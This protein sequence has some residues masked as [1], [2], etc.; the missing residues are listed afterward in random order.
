[1]RIS[2]A[3]GLVGVPAHVLRHWEDENVL[4][5]DRAPGNQRDYTAQHVDEARII[6]RLR[7]AGVGLATIRELRTAPPRARSAL[8]TSVADRMT[9]EAAQLR[10]AAD[11]LRH[12]T[13]CR[14]PVTAEC[15]DCSD[16]AGTPDP[17]PAGAT[18]RR[19]R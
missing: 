3:A 12:S 17:R 6:H 4:T 1:M 14:H 18:P 13:E 19:E 7:R 10:S 15:P 9:R 16:Y 8:L 11:F 2:Q 5:P